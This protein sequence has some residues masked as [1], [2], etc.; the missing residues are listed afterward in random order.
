M[1]S[2]GRRI[3][4]QLPGPTVDGMRVFRPYRLC[5][6]RSQRIDV[7]EREFIGVCV[8]GDHVGIP[9]PFM[10]VDRAAGH[11][12]DPLASGDAQVLPESA[13][14][15]CRCCGMG[16][17]DKVGPLDPDSVQT[18]TAVEADEAEDTVPAAG[19]N[20]LAGPVEMVILVKVRLI[21]EDEA[22]GNI[23]GRERGPGRYPTFR[24]GCYFR[25][26]S[27]GPG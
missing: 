2:A 22:R 16:L 12:Q 24:I 25:V 21:A 1:R 13:D 9:V 6:R 5:K 14:P 8:V 3:V 17:E 15:V 26:R 27:R 18:I 10:I 4:L 7:A 23:A 19:D 20:V 11:V